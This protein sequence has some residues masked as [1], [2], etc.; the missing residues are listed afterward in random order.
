MKRLLYII[1]LI[2]FFYIGSSA[3]GIGTWKSYMAYYTTTVVTEANEN[4]FAVANGSLYSYNKETK[5]VR[6]YFKQKGELSDTQITHMGFNTKVKRLL[7]IYSN[8]NIDIMGDQG[9]YN[10]A[11]LMNNTNIPDKD[12][13]GIFFY[14]K[15][16]Y[17]STAFGVILLDMD[18]QEI[19][20]TYRLN[21]QVLSTT[22]HNRNLFA[23]TTQGIMYGSM[24]DNLLDNNNWK[25]YDISLPGVEKDSIIQIESF[26]DH[27]CFFQPEQGIYYQAPDASIHSLYLNNNTI[28]MR[29]ENNKLMVYTTQS[30][31]IHNSIS[32]KY[33]I[34]T[35]TLHDISS[36]HDNTFWIAADHEGLKGIKRSGNNM[37]IILSGTPFETPKYDYAAFLNFVNGKLY[38]A[39][40][41]RWT[42]RSYNPGTFMI[43]NPEDEKWINYDEKEIAKQ[44]GIKFSDVTSIAIDPEDETHYFASTWGEG[45]FEFKDDQFIKLYRPSNTNNALQTASRSNPNNYIRVEGLTFDSNNNLWMTNSS[46]RNGI[47][48][49]QADG[50]WKSYYFNQLQEQHVIDKILIRNNN[51]K[52]VNVERGSNPGIL[53]FD[54]SSEHAAQFYTTIPTFGGGTLNAN[55]YYC[56]TEDKKGYI[57]VGTNLGPVYIGAPNDALEN[58]G[59]FTATRIVQTA[60][61]GTQTYFLDGES[62]KAIAVDGGNRKWLGTEASGMFVISTENDL[63]IFH[64]FT[65]EN[66]PLPSNNVESIAIDPVTGEVFIG[67]DKGIISYMSGAPEGNETFSDVYAF[68][69]PVRPEYQDMVTITGL[70]TDTNVKITDLNGNLIYQGT[71]LGGQFTWDCR[72]KN[73]ER[74][75][76]GVYLVLAK[77]NNQSE[78]IVTKIMVVK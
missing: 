24:D 59:R 55:T 60:E 48:V 36:L 28:G 64:H 75:S 57:W 46:V 13:N 76:T 27:L 49:R 42:D 29:L 25:N 43:Y 56:V 3:Q 8:G 61:N 5:E 17:L 23:A 67:T 41:G 54:E 18:K 15:Y 2:C 31:I 34:N 47:V 58:R 12:V 1:C 66:S 37:E 69:N 35:G 68:P 14:D 19:T 39:G 50:T 33:S 71:S 22:I 38:V 72:K 53:V 21:K 65:A 78:S 4:V 62:V 32:D 40:G 30:A 16:A 51:H 9:F 10:I 63:E 26:Q 52:W 44:S 73:G 6:T 74:V 70:K 77:D 45:V 20:E 7:I 11:S